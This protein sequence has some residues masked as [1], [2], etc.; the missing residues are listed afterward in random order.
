MRNNSETNRKTKRRPSTPTSKLLLL[1]SN[2]LALFSSFIWFLFRLH[3]KTRNSTIST[4]A[5]NTSTIPHFSFYISKTSRSS[6]RL[7]LKQRFHFEKI[8][9]ISRRSRNRGGHHFI[10]FLFSLQCREVRCW[11]LVSRVCCGCGFRADDD[12]LRSLYTCSET[13]R[14]VGWVRIPVF[15]F[16]GSFLGDSSSIYLPFC[17]YFFSPGF[18]F[19]NIFFSFCKQCGVNNK[20]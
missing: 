8:L 20:E 11:L 6:T 3:H 18:L 14:G 16:F 19:R 15:F 5:N 12:F 7:S 4:L 17:F 1:K 2:P 13:R 9:G 10:L